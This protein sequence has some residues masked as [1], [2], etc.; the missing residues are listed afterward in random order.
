MSRRIYAVLG[1]AV[2]FWGFSSFGGMKE[3]AA[4]VDVHITIGS[5]PAF[6]FQAPPVVVVI[7][8]TYVY[9]VPDIGVD[10]LFYDGFWYRPYEGHWFWARVFNGPWIY[11]P[12]E[13]IPRVLI[14]LPPEYHRVPSGY[15]RIP[16]GQLQRNWGRWE[17][18]RYWDRDRD[19]REGW[20]GGFER[21]RGGEERNR[22]SEGRRG[23][24]GRG[25]SGGRRD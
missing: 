23:F 7:P 21:R 14:T 3:A 8:G 25:R 11:L 18:E 22:G 1:A 19:W 12:P 4:G 6:F 2:I 16:Y 17:H 13:K 24:E 15:H 5:P 9:L 20:Q 10:I